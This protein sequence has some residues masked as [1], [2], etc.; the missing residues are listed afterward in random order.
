MPLG[1]P[2]VRSV[3]IALFPAALMA[4]AWTAQLG[5]E[6]AP[7]L[8]DTLKPN[9]IQSPST[10]DTPRQEG[11][12]VLVLRNGQLLQGRVIRVDDRYHVVVPEGLI[13]LRP[14]EV[15][16]VCRDIREAYRRKRAALQADSARE[17]VEL[18]RWCLRYALVDLAAEELA[19]AERLDA[20]HPM[21]PLVQRQLAMAL[22]PA[23]P[24]AVATKARVP[25]P[26]V[27]DLDR[28]VRGMPPQTVEAFVQAI[29]PMLINHCGL[30]ACHGQGAQTRFRLLR[31]PIGTQ[32]TRRLTQRNLYATLEWIDRED[33]GNSPLL[34]MP[35]H[36]HGTAR[37][38]V[39]GSPQ[40]A[41]YRQLLDWCYRVCQM[42]SPVVQASYDEPTE[43]GRSRLRAGGPRKIGSGTELAPR[44]GAVPAGA[45]PQAPAEPGRLS[46]PD[47]FAPQPGPP[48]RP[49]CSPAS[50]AT[51]PSRPGY[52][53]APSPPP[54]G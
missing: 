31:P 39:F 26:S 17:H 1:S 4:V 44:Q 9:A 21:I 45:N 19:E 5:A 18:A 28:M 12:S 43:A 20:S 50:P 24:A 3:A 23:E 49:D 25:G 30:A 10:A 52:T 35:A 7:E 46:R 13:R 47:Q 33:P 14:D 15:A 29:Q 42:E 53:T 6:G 48:E 37:A 54:P 32:P 2:L 38:P 36:P 34:S 22:Q 8:G 27:E 16:Y 40:M 11:Q 51:P 41:Q